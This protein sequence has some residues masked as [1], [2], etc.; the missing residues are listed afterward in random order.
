MPAPE[1]TIDPAAAVAA[2]TPGI[3]A[4]EVTVA[5]GLDAASLLQQAS[6]I[7]APCSRPG[8][9]FQHSGLLLA[10]LAA[11]P[12][13]QTLVAAVKRDG[14]TRTLWPLRIERRYGLKLATDLASPFAQ[15]SDV[16]GEPLDAGTFATLCRRLQAGIGVDAILC[17]GVRADS[18]LES[19]LAQTHEARIDEDAAPFVDLQALGNFETYAAQFSKHT[20]R[21][22]RQRRR[23]L[24]AEHGPLS[25][26]VLSGA[27]GRDAVAQ[28]L[29]WKGQWLHAQALSSRVVGADDRE[30]TLMA[31][32]AGPG[33]HVSVLRAGEKPVAIELGFSNG[34][35]YAAFMGAFDPALAGYSPGQEQ[36]TLTLAWCFTQGFARYDLLPP[37]D[38]YKLTWTRGQ[39][40]EPVR[41]YCVALTSLG[42]LYK[43]ARQHARAPIKRTVLGLPKDV[44]AAARRYGPA[45]AGLGATATLIGILTD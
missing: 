35:H 41:D 1:R 39:T 11:T 22:R 43:L 8:A 6:A 12:P 40:E 4:T 7:G 37:R 30:A 5:Q 25:F 18:G 24:E 15:Y 45:A 17:R 34:D 13:E 28:A 44:R 29:Q 20:L 33:T 19:V 38:A 36:M 26:T 31:A 2:V 9:V 21:T 23:K 14:G 3:G 32:I 27:E 10:S 16:I 42:T